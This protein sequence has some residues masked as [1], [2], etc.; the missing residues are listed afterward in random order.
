MRSDLGAPRGLK[1][2]F[3]RVAPLLEGSWLAL[4]AALR[5]FWAQLQVYCSA[6]ENGGRLAGARAWGSLQWRMVLGAGGSLKAVERLVD[7]DLAAWEGGDLVVDGY[8]TEA[9][10]GYRRKRTG[11]Q[12]GGMVSAQRRAQRE[13]E[14]RTEPVA[15]SSNGATN[16]SSNGSRITVE[17]REAE[18]RSAGSGAAKA[19]G[20]A[21]R[22]AGMIAGASGPDPSRSDGEA[23][24]LFKELHYA[25]FGAP[26][27]P[28]SADTMG[29]R[30]RWPE[31][32][33]NELPERIASYFRGRPQGTVSIA[34]FLGWY[35]GPRGRAVERRA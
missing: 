35:L 33:P 7:A 6:Q 34:T 5:G 20:V 16:A 19:G 9:E 21:S 23:V 27:V 14:A 18:G 29:M 22:G 26:Y 25:H 11:G 13:D 24:T 3:L 15:P 30:A 8:D 12:V 10:D 31:V 4:P 32:Q 17:D 1:R 28:T 2:V